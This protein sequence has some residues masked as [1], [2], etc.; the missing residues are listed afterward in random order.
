MAGQT[1]IIGGREAVGVTLGYNA[2]IEYRSLV[3]PVVPPATVQTPQ[4]LPVAT[5]GPPN[6]VVLKVLGKKLK[7][8]RK[9]IQR[10]GCSVGLVTKK[11]GAKAASAKIVRQS[12]NV[13]RV[14][15]PHTA[16]NL[17]LE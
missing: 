2:E 1:R 11:H 17:K 6:C 12:P 9:S 3:P 15:A 7:A 4:P 13:G 16:I 8:A 14:L 10:S 5:P